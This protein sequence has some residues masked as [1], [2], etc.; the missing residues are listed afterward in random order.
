MIHLQ[1]PYQQALTTISHR[2]F[3]HTLHQP[4]IF[5]N[6]A[7]RFTNAQRNRTTMITTAEVIPIGTITRTHGKQGQVQCMMKN[8]YWDNNHA[9]FLIL[10]IQHILTPFRVLD[11]HTKGN[12]YIIFQLAGI[13]NEQQA[14][15]L[16]GAETFMLRS[17]IDEDTPNLPTWQSLINYR[18]LDLEQG[19]LG[20]VTQVDDT[21]INTLLLLN[22]GHIIPI[23]EDF[24]VAL[25]TNSQT[26]TIRLPYTL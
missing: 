8:E 18:V 20:Y 7:N 15:P 3:Y 12:D 6:F 1:T 10:D 19:E 13:N 11:W 24:I 5:R 17:D 26:L 16:I 23:H 21:T 9:T 22:N 4:I 14:L 2:F 25:E